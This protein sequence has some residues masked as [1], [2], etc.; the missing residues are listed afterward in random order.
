M[1]QTCVLSKVEFQKSF[2]FKRNK[3]FFSHQKNYLFLVLLRTWFFAGVRNQIKS[4]AGWF[5]RK[6]GGL[7]GS[8]WSSSKRS[9]RL[10]HRRWWSND[11]FWPRCQL[12]ASWIFLSLKDLMQHEYWFVC[13]DERTLKLR[14]TNTLSDLIIKLLT[15]LTVDILSWLAHVFCGWMFVFQSFSK[16]N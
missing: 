14:Q 5:M 15:L 4:K 12:P 1:V 10:N 11:Q 7:G 8:T 6:D 2:H 3:E 16:L 13:W 9:H